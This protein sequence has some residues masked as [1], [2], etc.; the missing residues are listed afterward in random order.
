MWGLYLIDISASE[1][2]S[3]KVLQTCIID[4][5]FSCNGKKNMKIEIGTL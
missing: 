1:G 2:L 5:F 4:F 3:S